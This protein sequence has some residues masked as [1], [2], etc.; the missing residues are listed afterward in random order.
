[1]SQHKDKSTAPEHAEK[2]NGEIDV[3]YQGDRAEDESVKKPEEET[4]AEEKTPAQPEPEPN[5]ED[6]CLRLAA[7]FDNYKK[8][9]AREYSQIIKNAETQLITELTE[10]LDNFER[11]LDPEHRNAKLEEFVKGIDLIYGQFKSVL[12]KRGLTR[13]NAVGEPFD[14]EM[15]DAMMQIDSD[16]VPE[17]DVAGETA[18][19]YMLGDRVIRH[20]KVIVSRGPAK[21]EEDNEE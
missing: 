9:T 13:I 17:G 1:M 14:P 18:P 15:H 7:E 19:G 20:S 8:R 11:A 2:E 10:V 4:G 5:W 21:A 16:D 6:R 12:E 3:E